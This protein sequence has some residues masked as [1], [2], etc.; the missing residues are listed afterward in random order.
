MKRITLFVVALFCVSAFADNLPR[1]AVYVTGNVG[2]D[3]KKAL[4]TRMLASLVN[5]GRYKGIER[6]NS[7]LA[8]IEKEQVKQMSGDIDDSQISALGKQFGVKFVC[9]AD[10]TPAYGSFQVSARIVNVETAEVEFI[11]ESSSPLKSMDD[12]ARVSNEVVKNMFGTKTMTAPEPKPE[13]ILVPVPE[14][15]KQ[16]TPTVPL[17]TDEKV[18]FEDVFFPTKKGMTLTYEIFNKRAGVMK[19][20]GSSSISVKSVTGTA[21]NG[22][23]VYSNS[24]LLGGKKEYVANVVDGV[25]KLPAMSNVKVMVREDTYT[26]LPS[27]LT[28]GDILPDA[29]MSLLIG[30]IEYTET[31]TDRKCTGIEKITVPAGTFECYKIEAKTT[32]VMDSYTL[33]SVNTTWYARGIGKV[34]FVTYDPNGNQLALEELQKLVNK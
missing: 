32:A 13:P 16:A 7:F 34:K 11:G 8:E 9:I 17:A 22:T 27:K 4:G 14:Q 29:K 5:S 26:L 2:D 1:I 30:K 10:I 20:V 33:L 18:T 21:D 6:S 12:L 25:L 19:K 24:Q 31:T 15:I 28:P 23:I 3:E